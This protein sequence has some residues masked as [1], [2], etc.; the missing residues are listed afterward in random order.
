MNEVPIFETNGSDSPIASAASSIPFEQ[1]MLTK[2]EAAEY[3]QVTERTVEE[4]MRMRLVPYFRI[5]HTVRFR[6]SDLL[7]ELDVRFRVPPKRREP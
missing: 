3:F 6:M 5:G 1:R 2:Q 7:L 4:W